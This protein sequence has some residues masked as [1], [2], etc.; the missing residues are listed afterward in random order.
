MMCR[1]LDQTTMRRAAAVSCVCGA[2]AA[3]AGCAMMGHMRPAADSYTFDIGLASAPEI[4]AKATG[5]FK[6]FGYRIVKDDSSE[7]L[8]METQW[9]SRQP[10]DDEERMGGHE[11][12]SRIKLIGAP[13]EVAGASTMYH[14][15]LTVENRFV[16]T[17]A[18][19]RDA[20][21]GTSSARY[22]QAIVKG[23]ALA[24]GG[25]AHPVA[26]EPRPF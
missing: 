16:P 6:D 2:L 26:T 20:H 10:A 25:S 5:I 12:I 4:R 9:Q 1:R 7:S 11:I 23:M 22:A 14:V 8:H 17:R 13:G 3:T 15:L 21:E 24:F 19:R 18:T